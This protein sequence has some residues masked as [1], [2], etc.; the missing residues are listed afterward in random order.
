MVGIGHNMPTAVPRVLSVSGGVPQRDND[1]VAQVAPSDTIVLTSED[2][3]GANGA[4]IVAQEWS[5]SEAVE[6]GAYR[7]TDSNLV[8][9]DP[10]GETTAVVS[11]SGSTKT[12]LESVGR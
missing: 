4:S 10:E 8:F 7:P 12:R 11:P 9:V 1:G 3:Y 5:F 6:V 2:S